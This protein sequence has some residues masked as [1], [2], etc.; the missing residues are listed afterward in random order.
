MDRVYYIK[1]V[2]GFALGFK[3]QHFSIIHVFLIKSIHSIS[4]F[5]FPS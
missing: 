1:N 4:Y 5:Y 3:R 2:N